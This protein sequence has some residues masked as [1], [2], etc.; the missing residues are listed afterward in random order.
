MCEPAGSAPITA[1]TDTSAWFWSNKAR[2]A[3]CDVPKSR[4]AVCSVMMT[5]LFASSAHCARLRVSVLFD[6]SSALRLC[7]Y[8][9][10]QI[11]V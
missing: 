10:A 4:C 3:A 7:A 6:A 5:P 1:V 11:A 9:L 2:P 8:L